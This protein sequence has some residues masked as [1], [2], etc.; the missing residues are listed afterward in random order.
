MDCAGGWTA[1]RR[2]RR[3]HL[4]HLTLNRR[5]GFSVVANSEFNGRRNSGVS[6]RGAARHPGGATQ[7][8]RLLVPWPK[9]TPLIFSAPC[10]AGV[11][12]D[13]AQSAP[14]KLARPS[15][16]RMARPRSRRPRPWPRRPSRRRSDRLRW[17]RQPHQS[18]RSERPAMSRGAVGCASPRSRAAFLLRRAL[19]SLRRPSGPRSSGPRSRPWPSSPRSG[20]R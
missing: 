16:P 12:T 13:A 11:H 18:E 9:N 17:L 6:G 5:P 10:R 20:S 19:R 3:D 1:L 4:Q 15:R 14:L 2:C 7:G 8:A